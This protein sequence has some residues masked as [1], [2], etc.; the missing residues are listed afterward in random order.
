VVGRADRKA[1]KKNL[2][3]NSY[4][5]KLTDSKHVV[6]VYLSKYQT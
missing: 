6:S 4:F 5:Q 3:L 1:K 2:L